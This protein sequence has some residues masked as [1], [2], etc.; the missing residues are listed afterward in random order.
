MNYFVVSADFELGDDTCT[1]K[2]IMIPVPLNHTCKGR[3]QPRDAGAGYRQRRR[4]DSDISWS[5]FDQHPDILMFLLN[6]QI[7][8][9]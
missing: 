3:S 4:S 7:F 6:I 2:I 5:E 8:Q 1:T 9:T